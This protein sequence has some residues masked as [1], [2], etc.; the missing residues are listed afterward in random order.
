MLFASSRVY[1]P[2]EP[3]RLTGPRSL[4]QDVS[5]L[6]RYDL[7]GLTGPNVALGLLGLLVIA[8]LAHAY[9]GRSEK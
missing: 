1:A 7:S 2:G 5:V 4:G 3:G 6:G 8:W 9:L